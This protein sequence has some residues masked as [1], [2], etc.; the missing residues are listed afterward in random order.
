MRKY[1]RIM[2]TALLLSVF[3]L[4][5]GYLLSSS[6]AVA[7]TPGGDFNLITDQAADQ[8][9]VVRVYFDSRAELDAV[10]GELDIWEVHHSEGYFVAM[11]SPAQR[12]WLVALD[13]RVE[14]DVEKTAGL[15]APLDA[16]YHYFDS[17]YSNSN[18]NYIVNT[19][20]WVNMMNDSTTELIDI[21]NA[22]QADHGGYHRDIWV[23]RI[24]NE[25]PA[26][27]AIEDKPP[28]FLFA[29]A[30]AREVTTPEMALRY[31][32]YLTSGYNGLGGYNVDPDVTWLVD[33]HVIYVLASVNPDGH[34]INE[35]DTGL[36]RRK[37][38]DNDD[39]CTTSGSWG[40]D[41]NRNSSFKWGCC[42]GSSGSACVDTY[43]GPSRASEPE[44]AAFQTYFASIFTDW[45]GANGD[46]VIPP[47]APD[48]AMGIFISLHTYSDLVLWPWGHTGTDAPNGAQLTTI[49][50]KF[51]YFNN[52]TPQQAMDLYTTDGTTDDWTYG[53]FG[54]ASF[55]FEMGPEYGGCSGFFP[56]FGCQDGID[57]QPQN[58]WAENRPAFIYAHKIAATP[59][60]TAYG[61]DS[62]T[63]AVNPASVPAGNSFALTAN[64]MDHRFGGDA[65]GEVNAAEYFIDAP[66]A[67][68][69][70]TAMTPVDGS[71]GGT[72]ENVQAS[73]V[74][75]YN[76]S[77]G[78][79]YLLVHGRNTQ[80]KWGPF[81]AVFFQVTQPQYS[82]QLTTAQDTGSADPGQVFTYTLEI[83]NMGSNLDTYDIQLSSAW[84]IT[85]S[86]TS[87]GP[88]ATG[89][90]ASFEVM[91][92][93]PS[94]AHNGE[95]DV[96]GVTA[97]SQGA[98]AVYQTLILNTSANLYQPQASPAS[99]D[100]A[101]HP[102]EQV[103]Y[104]MQIINQG[105]APDTFTIQSA[106]LWPLTLS[107]ADTGPLPV[108]GSTD[109]TITVTIPLT[110]TAGESD[111]ATLTIASQ[112]DPVKQTTA[113]LTTYVGPRGPDLLLETA[114]LSGDPGAAVIYW[115]AVTNIGDAA[116]TFSLAVSGATWTV[117]APADTGLVAA[118]ASIT[119]PVTVSVPLDAAAGASDLAQ[120]TFASPLPGA[121][122]DSISLQTTAN[123]VYGVTA[124]AT[125][126][127]QTG[128]AWGVPVTY[129]LSL[130]NTGNTTDTFDVSV[131]SG[132]QVDFEPLAGPLGQG[133]GVL[134]TIVVYVPLGISS[135]QMD[136]AVVTITS[137]GN[138]SR[139]VQV[140]LTT[141]TQWHN[142][143]LP[144]SIRQ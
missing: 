17:N 126:N 134:L 78:K 4:L 41:L 93:V 43:R 27:G 34:R 100:G 84:P 131:V 52:Y 143:Y 1:Y 64:V 59:Y 116:D 53:K 110:A 101:A 13:Y 133:E 47:A 125:P 127:A 120:I 128:L 70:G 88:L 114:A 141:T 2:F 56:A 122:Q 5:S 26:Y 77:V 18:G 63:L 113:T 16:R 48:N 29:N 55:T 73:V 24:T 132:W 32:L 12:D 82:L 86:A 111:I 76:L 75:G 61:P 102:G 118:G 11:M 144:M 136:T 108:D 22:W 68:G 60:I 96:A 23:L 79:H 124:A 54:V 98:P 71:W 94:D 117:Q 74:A 83:E 35:A 57:G 50:R 14:I 9:I 106:A 140:N 67:D 40:V 103:V 129:T 91:V 72:S 46:D 135:G 104:T 39:G 58:F 15:M 37:N 142:V 137:Q 139:Q 51:A 21:G 95:G 89:A 92:T 7:S 33:H 31:I 97:T 85:T 107:A 112:S 81:T 3:G 38:M 121:Q 30:H 45:N 80:G 19:L 90:S 49:G 6:T 28:F 20:Q 105:S 62:Q 87:I 8:N 25:D 36:N 109:L 130:T 138:I 123:T 10:S 42:G 65:L 66:G 115:L 99:Q 119:V 69:S 44:I